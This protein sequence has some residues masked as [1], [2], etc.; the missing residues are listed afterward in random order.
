MQATTTNEYVFW[1]WVTH[2]WGLDFF[3]HK[4]KPLVRIVVSMDGIRSDGPVW[5]NRDVV[6]NIPLQDILEITPIYSATAV[7]GGVRITT[8]ETKNALPREYLFWP[9]NPFDPTM[10]SYNNFAEVRA[11]VRIANALMVN[12]IPEIDENPYLRQL[13][14]QDLPPYIKGKTDFQ[15]DKN[16][17]PWVYYDDLVPASIRKKV[18][19]K[20]RMYTIVTVGLL[21]S[22]ILAAAYAVVQQI[23]R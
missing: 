14:K 17:S 15:W 2:K 8:K 10:V 13:K 23:I 7:H 16:V 1:C 6:L 12:D 20:A 11:F 3:W 22:L 4:W 21:S 5:T 18:Q 19:S 9:V